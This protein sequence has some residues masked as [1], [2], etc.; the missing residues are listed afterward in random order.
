MITIMITVTEAI[1]HRHEKTETK[2][3]IIGSKVR[4]L[5]VTDDDNDD[6]DDGSDDD[7]DDGNDDNDD[8]VIG[9]DVMTTTYDQPPHQRTIQGSVLPTVKDTTLTF[10]SPT[11]L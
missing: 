11:E 7:D 6:D 10:Q 8:V 3:W 5:K 1:C 9:D 4:V 2:F